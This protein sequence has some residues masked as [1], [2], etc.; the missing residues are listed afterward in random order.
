MDNTKELKDDNGSF[1]LPSAIPEHMADTSVGISNTAAPPAA[2]APDPR[3]TAIPLKLPAVASTSSTATNTVHIKAFI[4]RIMVDVK[5]LGRLS[6]EGVMGA[7]LARETDGAVKATC[8]AIVFSVVFEYSILLIILLNMICM[9]VKGPDPPGQPSSFASS[10]A[11]KSDID[12]L[13]MVDLIVTVVFTVEAI[14]KIWL[15]GFSDYLSD[16]YSRFDFVSVHAPP[17]CFHFT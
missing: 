2:G 3:H 13:D 7:G 12:A 16:N 8:R 6:H 17:N 10:I 11:E 9:M 14:L 1:S 15:Q 5:N 4:R